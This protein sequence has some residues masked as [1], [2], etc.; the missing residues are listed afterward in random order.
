MTII[1][2]KEVTYRDLKSS[3]LELRQL[4]KT[5]EINKSSSGHFFLIAG[6]YNSKE[7]VNTTVKVFAKVEGRYR[8]IEMPISMIRIV[9]DNNLKK[10]YIQVEYWHHQLVNDEEVL[11][12]VSKN[13]YVIY[14]PE[15]YLPEKLLPI[16]L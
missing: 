8:I 12:S 15:Q 9:I 11:N 7:T 14:C 16:E 1:S 4:V 13:Y 3:N 10:P 5:T 2:C 6:S